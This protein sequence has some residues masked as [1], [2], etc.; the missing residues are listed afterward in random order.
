VLGDPA[1]GSLQVTGGFRIGDPDKI[2]ATLAGAFRLR[3]E[4]SADGR[5]LL[6]G[7]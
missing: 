5:L 7:K 6:F 1:L 2:A 3:V 4:R